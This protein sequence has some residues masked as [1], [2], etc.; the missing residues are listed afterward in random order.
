M[1]SSE[2]AL[3]ALACVFGGALLGRQLR[4][5]LP[6]HHLKDDTKD[7]VKLAIGLIATLAALVLG[8]LISSAKESFSSVSNELTHVAV[9]IIQLDRALARYGSEAAP[10]RIRIKETYSAGVNLLFSGDKA[11][12][13]KLD[14]PAA[15]AKSEAIHQAIEQLAPRDDV[16]RGLRSQALA[17]TNEVFGARWLVLLQSEGTVS[18]PLL[19]VLVAW[20]TVNFTAFGLF[21]PRNSTLLVA[22]FMCALCVS[23][24]IFLILEMDRPLEGWV[25]ISDA[26]MRAALAHLGQ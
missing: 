11:Q 13:A 15:V 24:A 23:G 3:I 20:L 25:R 2:I 14:T 5:L 9:K 10:I 16:Q 17:L 22:L 26:P 19:V 1:S 18:W 4:A 12:Q 7:I 8:L 21:G 6:E